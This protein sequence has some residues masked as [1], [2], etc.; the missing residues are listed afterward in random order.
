MNDPIIIGIDEVGRGPVFGPMFIAA[1]ANLVGWKIAG[2][3]DS[4]EIKNERA[5]KAL[6]GEIRHNCVWNVAEISA[7]AINAYGT[8]KT[9]IYAGQKVAEEIVKRVRI[10]IPNRPIRVIFDGRDHRTEVKDG[11]SVE[12]IEKADATIFE[13]SCAS[14]IAK[15]L[16]DDRI[17]AFA[18]DPRYSKYALRKSRGYPTPEH[19]LMLQEHGLSDL[20]RNVACRTFLERAK[21]NVDSQQTS[22]QEETNRRG[23]RKQLFPA[24]QHQR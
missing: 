15:S 20:H 14:I 21:D 12:S 13:C 3:R 16:H 5:R 22:T 11:Y 23:A 8:H 2:I 4:K 6:A 10:M 17:N 9:L 19:K 1:T 18:E 7:E 24:Q